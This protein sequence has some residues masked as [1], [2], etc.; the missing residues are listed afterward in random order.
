M[1]FLKNNKNNSFKMPIYLQLVKVLRL[2]MASLNGPSEL[3]KPIIKHRLA[4]IN[5]S[6]NGKFSIQQNRT[7][8]TSKKY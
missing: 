8:E 3:Q 1:F 5:M 4:M 7:N 6:N 2:T